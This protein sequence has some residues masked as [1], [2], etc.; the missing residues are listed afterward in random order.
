MMHTRP[1]HVQKPQ[2]GFTLL[3]IL[4][5]TFL[6]GIATIGITGLAA[7]GTRFSVESERQN[8]AQAV[9]NDR[10]EYIRSLPFDDV[11]Y[12]DATGQEPDGVLTRSEDIQR[13][14]QTYHTTITV[15][16]IDNSQN[17]NLPA[18]GLIE[19]N[20]DYKLVT[21]EA[22]WD[23]A[24]GNQRS[25]AVTTYVSRGGNLDSCTPG[26]TS[27]PGSQ[28]C[29]DSGVCKNPDPT[30]YCPTEAYFCGG[31]LSTYS[32]IT[33]NGALYAYNPTLDTLPVLL[34]TYVAP[35]GGSFFG[36]IDVA[37]SSS[38]DIY[39]IADD[40]NPSTN[41]ELYKINAATGELTD[42]GTVDNTYGE[43]YTSAEFLSDG[44]LAVGGTG[45][46]K[47]VT[48]SS[49]SITNID[50]TNL[51]Y[52]VFGETVQMAG[53]LVEISSG[54]TIF[55]TGYADSTPGD[56]C[57]TLDESTGD[58]ALASSTSLGT[59]GLDT[60]LFCDNG[61]CSTM[62][63]FQQWGQIRTINS[64]CQVISTQSALYGNQWEGATR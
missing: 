9:V 48:L 53:D 58:V 59:K 33:T 20:A 11:G 56:M 24:S 60:G 30:P 63:V 25:V 52:D 46:I 42:I 18:G 47:F 44:R 10:I 31:T 5:A 21:V 1:I 2:A 54:S 35:G 61:S 57:F 51:T 19:P 12:T 26:V 28:A 14:Q 29:P 8:V 40:G 15:E 38:G 13:N 27:C 64:S 36:M 45:K 55:F 6:L 32:F 39:G 50:T 41:T 22:V 4:I 43:K 3:E 16:L 34:V 17:G 7:L 62:H 37:K 49:G 23:S